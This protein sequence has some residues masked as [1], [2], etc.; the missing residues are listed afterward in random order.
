MVMLHH[1]P[2]FYPLIFPPHCPPPD[3]CAR[4]S[5]KMIRQLKPTVEGQ[6]KDFYSVFC[7]LVS[8][9][10]LVC[11]G[12]DVRVVERRTDNQ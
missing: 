12:A 1:L 6:M 7:V 10:Q 11:P 9:R 4:L 2:A 3:K 8:S 5:A